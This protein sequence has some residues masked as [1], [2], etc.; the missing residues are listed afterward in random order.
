MEYLETHNGINLFEIQTVRIVRIK[1][2]N[3]MNRTFDLRETDNLLPN[4]LNSV[5]STVQLEIGSV[6]ISE[7]H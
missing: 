2:F 7:S 1:Q 3:E 6:E 5:R 4:L